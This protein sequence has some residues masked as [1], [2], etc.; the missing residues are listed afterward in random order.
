MPGKEEKVSS[1]LRLLLSLYVSKDALDQKTG[2]S[3]ILLT[4]D[5]A[6]VAQQSN[7]NRAY[8]AGGVDIGVF[9]ARPCLVHPSIAK[10][11]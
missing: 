2:A 3:S 9:Q 10:R 8:E 11:R 7:V 5:R 1:K 4:P 6:R